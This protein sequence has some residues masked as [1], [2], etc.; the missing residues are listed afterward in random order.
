MIRFINPVSETWAIDRLVSMRNIRERIY[1]PSLISG[2]KRII[3]NYLMIYEPTITLDQV[4]S[5][6]S[7]FE[8][9][10]Q[11]FDLNVST[12]EEEFKHSLI[13]TKNAVKKQGLKIIIPYMIRGEIHD[14]S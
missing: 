10:V 5:N 14:H 11:Y 4:I 6:T 1:F 9:D 3:V 8:R 7:L 2:P 12:I 13:F